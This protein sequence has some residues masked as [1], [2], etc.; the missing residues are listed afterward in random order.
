[1]T[2]RVRYRRVCS[3]RRLALLARMRAAKE[4]KR[5]ER[6]A[7]GFGPEPKMQREYP[8]EIGFRDKRSGEVAWTE[9]RSVRQA[10]RLVSV[11]LREWQ[12]T[13]C[14]D[15]LANLSTFAGDKRGGAGDKGRAA[16]T[17][18]SN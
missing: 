18:W 17:G 15:R 14:Q 5:R 11:M 6:V 1:M 13:P 7:E 12:P 10:M 2:K 8:L 9:L 3:P 4:L 16:D